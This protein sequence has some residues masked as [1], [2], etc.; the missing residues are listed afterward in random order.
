MS[1]FDIIYVSHKTRR[2]CHGFYMLEH[3]LGDRLVTSERD[4]SAKCHANHCIPMQRAKM[5]KCHKNL[6]TDILTPNKHGHFHLPN[7]Y[8]PIDRHNNYIVSISNYRPQI[9]CADCRDRR[10]SL[11]TRRNQ[12]SH[13]E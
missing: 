10:A 1:T 9:V 12:P 11:A 3:A 6:I 8:P 4:A 13:I 7:R 5:A 2:F